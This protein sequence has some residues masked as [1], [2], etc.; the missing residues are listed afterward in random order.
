MATK[1]KGFSFEKYI[2]IRKKLKLLTVDSFY[3]T[4]YNNLINLQVSFKLW[5]GLDW[6]EKYLETYVG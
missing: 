2:I 5:K 1:S 4:C 6:N 3:L